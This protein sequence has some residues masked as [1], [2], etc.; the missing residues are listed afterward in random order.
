MDLLEKS[1]VRCFHNKWIEQCGRGSLGALGWENE[2]GQQKR[3]EIL[4]QIA[5][6]S[7]FSILDLGCGYGHF[8]KFLDQRFSNFSYTGIDFMPEFIEEAKQAY[9]GCPNTQFLQEDFSVNDIPTADY[10]FASG[11][12]CYQSNDLTYYTDVIKKMIG[13]ARR[14]VGF[15]ML[16]IATFPHSS[17]LKAH[18]RYTTLALCKSLAKKVIVTENYLPDDFTIFIYKES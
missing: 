13:H 17:F 4:A 11:V 14:G 15:N 5:N 2:V 3:F 9:A 8:K 1:S 12:F 16:N 18:E 6:L 10:I 7:N